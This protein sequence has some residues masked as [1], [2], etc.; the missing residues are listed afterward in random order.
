[1][2]QQLLE[3]AIDE[4]LDEVGPL[5]Q[6]SFIDVLFGPKYELLPQ[7]SQR[8]EIDLAYGETQSLSD[9][10]LV[11][12][13]AYLYKGGWPHHESLPHLPASTSSG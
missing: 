7:V 12:R 6:A 13:S 1:M 2:T 11:N 3:N 10:E 5:Y 9:Y 8:Y 4:R